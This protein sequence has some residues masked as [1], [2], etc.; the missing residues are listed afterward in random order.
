VAGSRPLVH[1]LCLQAFPL[2]L[3]SG[4]RL[5]PGPDK[6]PLELVSSKA[7]PSGVLLQTYRVETG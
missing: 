5:Y 2:S 4:A 7:V 6:R 1:S 3:G